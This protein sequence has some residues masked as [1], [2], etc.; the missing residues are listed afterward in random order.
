MNHLTSFFC[1]VDY[2]TNFL[3]KK[4]E[5]GKNHRIFSFYQLVAIQYYKCASEGKKKVHEKDRL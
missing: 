3:E 4:E 2:V 1:N 5:R